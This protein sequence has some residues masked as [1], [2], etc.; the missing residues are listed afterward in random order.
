RAVEAAAS[1]RGRRAAVRSNTARGSPPAR[2]ALGRAQDRDR[3]AVPWL[4]RGRPRA[5]GIV[6]GAARGQAAAGG[7]AE[8]PAATAAEEGAMTK[9]ALKTAA[10]TA[11]AI[12]K[13]SKK[14]Q[15]RARSAT[16][17]SAT[18]PA[19]EGGVRFT[20]PDRVYWADV[21]VTKQDLAD[22]YRSVW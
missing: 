21:G 4:D 12:T 13:T 5:S 3:G 19:A 22:Y 14:A 8:R 11:R 9:S 16:K 2:R 1:A 18:A 6:Q 10:E 17:S 15:P 20:H 7:R